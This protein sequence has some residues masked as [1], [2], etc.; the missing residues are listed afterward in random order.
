VRGAIPELQGNAMLQKSLIAKR[1]ALPDIPT[2]FLE[3]GRRAGYAV[4]R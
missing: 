2:Y 1:L 4:R 3:E